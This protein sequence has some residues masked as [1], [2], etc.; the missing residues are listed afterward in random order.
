MTSCRFF[1][2]DLTFKFLDFIQTLLLRVR[3]N[4]GQG[5]I[6][7]LFV[8]SGEPLNGKLNWV[9]RLLDNEI[10]DQRFDEDIDFVDYVFVHFFVVFLGH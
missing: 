9:A 8:V 4:L 10:I 6:L 2:N 7:H 3:V 1:R 5:L